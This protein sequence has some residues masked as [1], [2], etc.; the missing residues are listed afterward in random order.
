MADYPHTPYIEAVV[1][2][3]NA[4]GVTVTAYELAAN[5]CFAAEIDLAPEVS[6]GA[7]GA[8]KVTL[9]WDEDDDWIGTYQRGPSRHGERLHIGSVPAPERVVESA[10]HFLGLVDFEPAD[11]DAALAAYGKPNDA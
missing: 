4:A 2:A 11:R 10:R 1:A 7:F 9:T 5:E 8:D 6:E 3:L